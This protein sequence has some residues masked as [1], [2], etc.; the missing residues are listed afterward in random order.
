MNKEIHIAETEWKVMEIL[1]AK[2]M[3]T[4]G[5]IKEALSDTGWS[6]STIKTLVRRLCTKG[7]LAIDDA[8]TQFLYYPL[9]NESEC[10]LKE[11]KNLINRIYNGSVKMLMANLASES[12]LTDE[13]TKKLMDIID[14]MEGGG[15]K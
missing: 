11:T 15:G 6:D 7:A 12:R 4:I 1:W 13:E 2:S 8:N 10:K 14:K 9:V 5:E 3:L